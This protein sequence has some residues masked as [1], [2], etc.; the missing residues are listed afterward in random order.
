MRSLHSPLNHLS[1]VGKV[2]LELQ[3]LNLVASRL[4]VAKPTTLP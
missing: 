2:L 3:A 1:E 4:A